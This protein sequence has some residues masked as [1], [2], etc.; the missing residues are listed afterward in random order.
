[1]PL[2]TTRP[3]AISAL[4]IS[5]ELVLRLLEE[6]DAGRLALAYRRN[7]AHLAPWE[8]ARIADFFTVGAQRE[9]VQ[10]RL[11]QYEAGA[12]LPLVLASNTD[13][14]GRMTLSGIVRGPFESASVGYWIDAE[15]TGRGL[16][17]AVLRATVGLARDQLGLHRLEAST[18]VHNLA[19]QRVLDRAGFEQI[20][21]APRYLKIA[22]EWQDH[23]LFQKILHD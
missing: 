6:G 18:L 15:L 17:S 16:A 13:I 8:P 7:R 2:P 20:G 9:A 5:E 4:A 11:A 22:G 10:A 1:V 14:V 23:K 3:L 19:S 12:A 21:L